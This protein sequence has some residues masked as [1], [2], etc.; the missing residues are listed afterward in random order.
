MVKWR[1]QTKKTN[2]YVEINVEV[3]V[4]NKRGKTLEMNIGN[5][6]KNKKGNKKAFVSLTLNGGPANSAIMET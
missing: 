4:P 6:Q 5:L 2:R 1:L 3:G